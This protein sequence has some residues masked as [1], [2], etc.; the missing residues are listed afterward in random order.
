M[1]LESEDPPGAT[2]R[3]YVSEAAQVC[4]YQNPP[5]MFES[6]TSNNVCTVIF[7]RIKCVKIRFVLGSDL[8]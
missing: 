5:R 2:S 1:N 3:D 4:I 6:K 8:L 7:I